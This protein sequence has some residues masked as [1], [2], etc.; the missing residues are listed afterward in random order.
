MLRFLMTAFG[1]LLCGVSVW[2]VVGIAAAQILSKLGNGAHDGGGAMG[3]FFVIGG[4]GSVP[5]AVIGAWVIWRVLADPSRTAVVGGSLAG[6]LV[7]LV[8]G[9]VYSMTPT[10]MVP[11]DFAEGKRGQFEVE[12][13]FPPDEAAALGSLASVTCQLRGGGFFMEVPVDRTRFRHEEDRT[14]LPADFKLQEVREWILAVM[15]GDAQLATA[16]VGIDRFIGPMKQSTEWTAW[17]PA[18]HGLEVRW[19]FAVLQK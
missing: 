16:T 15:N 19:R 2:C 6:L 17:A 13:R 8:A 4:L 12:V 9:L 10:Q 14:V 7:V 5:G 3:G 11:N 18:D 1:G